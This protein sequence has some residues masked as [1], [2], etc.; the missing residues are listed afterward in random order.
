VTDICVSPTVSARFA[1][2]SSRPVSPCFG[3]LALAVALLG[4]TACAKDPGTDGSTAGTTTS[5]T[6]TN[7]TESGEPSDTSATT[8]DGDGDGDTTNE[9]I[10]TSGS[11]YAGPEIDYGGG[12]YGCDPWVQDCPDGEKCVP[13]STDGE[14]LNLQQVR[15]DHRQR[16]AR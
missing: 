15:G 7:A 5:M 16:R 3:T 13:Y 6:T 14:G 1:A 8:G 11:F 4:S 12:P 9:S 10:S 2:P